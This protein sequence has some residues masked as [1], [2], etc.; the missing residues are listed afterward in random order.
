MASADSQ[1]LTV[2]GHE[3]TLTHPA[4]ILYP[5]TGTT[6][7]DVVEY[8]TRIAPFLLPHSTDRAATRKRWVDGVGSPEEPGAVFFQKNLEDSA[9][10]WV[11]RRPLQHADDVNI[12]PLVNDAATLVWLAQLAALEIHVPQW[13]FGPHGGHRAPDRLVLDLDPGEGAGLAECAE[14]A[15]LARVRL[16]G[17]GLEPVPVTSGSK[18]IHLYA[19]L[20]G[21]R[22]SAAVSALAHELAREL[23]SDHADLVVSDMKRS[24]RAG[25]V[26]VDWSQ[27]SENKTTVVPYSLRGR[28]T[29]TVA[30][31][32]HWAE[33]DDPAL[34]QLHYREVLRRVW[35][36]DDPMSGFGGGPE[37]V[38]AAPVTGGRSFVIQELAGRRHGI[39]LSVHRHGR[40][41]RWVLPK[42]LPTDPRHNQAAE[43][44]EHEVDAAGRMRDS[45]TYEVEKWHDDG[46]IILTVTG[47]HG[48]HRLALIN[49]EAGRSDAW[50]VHLLV[51]DPIRQAVRTLPVRPSAGPLSAVRAG[52]ARA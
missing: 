22:S 40:S 16:Q 23:E 43:R 45:G 35:G 37:T 24:L 7:R 42:G 8:Y 11:K 26:L 47:A 33:L 1:T 12:Y 6:K 39:L 44:V 34:A 38:K 9:P 25:K 15:R 48:S 49:T 27:N 2:E 32:R 51:A 13:R 52:A 14:V 19:A 5:A 30:A 50:L 31:P 10:A 18:G 20:D 41:Y 46:E 3:L 28:F 29:P 21:S 4:K 36:G 17:M